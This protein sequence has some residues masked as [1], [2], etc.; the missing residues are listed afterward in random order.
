METGAIMSVEGRKI[1]GP[2][3]VSRRLAEWAAGLRVEDLPEDVRQAIA[4]TFVDTVGLSIAS[5]ETDYGQAVRAAADVEGPC[6]VFGAA[7]Q[8]SPYDAALVNGTT[9]HGEDFDNTY[10]GCPV[11]SG[12]VVVPALSA[13]GE[14]YKLPESR[15]ALGMAVAIEVM[16]RLG[17]LAQKG[18]HKQGFHPT[19]VLGTVA[20]AAGVAVARGLG[21][22]QI[23]DTLGISASM[24]SGIIEYLADGTW[25]KRMHP[26]WAAQAA[27]R[28]AAMGE[29]GFR[30]P[31]SVFE[32]VHGLYSAFAP[33]VEPD[34]EALVGDL[35]ERWEA[36]SVAFKP[37]ACGTMTQPYIDCAVRLARGGVNHEE[38]EEVVCKVGEGTVH[39]LWAP[40]ELKQQ[41]PTAYAAKFSGPYTVAA[42]FVFGDAGLSEFTE[43]AIHDPRARVLAAK[44][45]Y[46]VDPANEYPANYTG[47]VA[48]RLT[49]GKWVS[50]EQGQLRGGQREPM[51]REDILGKC[52]AN[53]AF[54]DWRGADAGAFAAFADGLFS[55]ERPFSAGL[56]ACT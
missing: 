42:G 22:Q 33:S 4:N 26:G 3:T 11:H 38:I 56:L 21:P 49:S 8:R 27:I 52:A 2:T 29:A 40:L 36:A 7:E 53:L 6:T 23:Q 16:C 19:S 45:R 55:G 48:A 17:A 37:Y 10:E 12:V 44:V 15:V 18:V 25:T 24:S 39:R 9:G 32:G 54:G 47:H 51:T 28:A 34:F 30:G 31:V 43:E 1:E 41:P 14:R 20:A 5:V 50:E 46:E 35:G 13:V